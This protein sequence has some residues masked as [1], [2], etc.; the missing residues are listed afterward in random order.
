[1]VPRDELT[2]KYRGLASATKAAKATNDNYEDNDIL[3]KF[4]TNEYDKLISR[5]EPLFR[6][7]AWYKSRHSKLLTMTSRDWAIRI[8]F[9][10][11]MPATR[12]AVRAGRLKEL[13]LVEEQGMLVIRGRASSGLK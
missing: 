13:T 9:R 6:W 2:A 4:V 5:T 3:K 12:I 11:A 10:T 7:L 1:M 8:W